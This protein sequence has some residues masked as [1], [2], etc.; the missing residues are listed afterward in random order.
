MSE[1]L[2]RFR[3]HLEFLGVEAFFSVSPPDNQYLTGFRTDFGEISSAI[4]V[5]QTAA[6]FLTDSRYTEQAGEQVSGFDIDEV[7]GDV[8]ARAGEALARLGVSTAAFDPT[9]LTVSELDRAQR[10]FNGTFAPML[11][12]VTPLRL[13]KSAEE[14][15]TLREASALAEGVL[16]D[17]VD[18]LKVGD[19]E[20]EIAARIEYEFRRRGAEG[21][22]FGAIALFGARGSLPHGIPGARTL[23]SG[24][25]V[26][27]DLG[28]RLHGYC[29]DL[30]RTYAFGTI[31]GGWFKEIYELTL[32]AQLT[33]LKKVG[34]GVPCKEVDAAARSVIAE[35]GFGSNFGHGLG[36]GVG[37]EIHEA[38]RLNAESQT[39]L[40]PGMV[41]TVE[42][43][44]YL[45]SQGGVR[46]EDLIVV[47]EDGFE[48]LSSTPKDLRVLPA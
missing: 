48:I 27:I 33:A 26:L 42:P 29:S 35:G 3:A 34:P 17:V 10:A 18:S 20:S 22:S 9:R 16:A 30:T 15:E 14:I 21:A 24:D 46:I 44:I 36:H 6:L 31:P 47:T 5:T 23:A 39:L 40:E 37:I 12:L 45:P 11:D 4:I 28:C 7:R 2:D 25:G 38:P 1:R 41:V 43:G 32:T 19:M 8:L 13:I